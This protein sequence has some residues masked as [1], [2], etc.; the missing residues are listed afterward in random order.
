MKRIF[1]FLLFFAACTFFACGV[2]E[3]IPVIF[4]VGAIGLLDM[5]EGILLVCALVLL[6]LLLSHLGS[7]LGGL[8][9]GWKLAE[10]SVFGLGLHRD[11]ENRLRLMYRQNAQP[12][13]SLMLPPRLDGGSPFGG[14]YAGYVLLMAVVGVVAMLLACCLR[15]MHIM[16]AVF[17][18]GGFM[19]MLSLVCVCRVLPF[20]TQLR[21]NVHLRRAYEVNSLTSAVSRRGLGVN[22]MPEEA[23]VPFPEEAL[24]FSQAFVA[25]CNTCTR[26]LND[27]EYAR[28]YELLLQLVDVLPRKALRLPNKIVWEQMLML[29]GAIAEM[30]M[31][32]APFLSEKL[33]AEAMKIINTPGWYER[34]LLAR[35]MRA[36]LVTKE[37]GNAENLLA[38]LLE[39]LDAMPGTQAMGAR[40]ILADVQALAEASKSE[41]TADPT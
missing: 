22:S 24:L 35:Y 13:Q 10:F 18:L 3:L 30:L 7:L 15:A 36:L 4:G 2:A 33:G 28:A 9:T 29:N 31:G 8:L 41:G 37:E 32:A 20:Y 21:K 6:G 26:L 17:Q 11:K 19:V 38:A 23:F 16:P 14:V 12:L 5:P 25:Q 27:G 34:L 40:R 1:T 39:R